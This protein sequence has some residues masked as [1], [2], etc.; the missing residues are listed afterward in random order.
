MPSQQELIQSMLNTIL[1]QFNAPGSSVYLPSYLQKSGYDP[2]SLKGGWNFG[3][4]TDPHFVALA[5]SICGDI[6]MAGSPCPGTDTYIGAP[7]PPNYPTLNLVQ[8]VINGFSNAFVKS[9]TAQ[10]DG[11]TVI[12]EIDLSTL[13]NFPPQVVINGLFTFTQFC[14]CSSDGKTCATA[15]K[16]EV[17]QGTFQATI[18]AS[19]VV[20]TA[21]ITT[22]A[23]DNLTIGATNV[24]YNIPPKPSPGSGPNV[25]I[26]VDITSLNVKDRTNA[27]QLA[28]NAFNSATALQYILTQINAG[29]NQ[30]GTLELISNILTTQIDQYLQQNHMYPYNG[31]LQA[32]F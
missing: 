21:K 23:K 8:V 28:N 11:V 16:A 18:P 10:A 22:L 31:A 26:V 20:V 5:N 9:L 6:D 1:P 30:S 32:L 17:G 29:A 3:Q 25:S 24:A 7:A 19:S 13:P 12:G 15:P 2:Y 4:I 27:N 14:C